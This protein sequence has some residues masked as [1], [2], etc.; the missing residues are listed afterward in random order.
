MIEELQFFLQHKLCH[1]TTDII[2]AVLRA[3]DPA[4]E[5]GMRSSILQNKSRVSSYADSRTSDVDYDNFNDRTGPCITGFFC[6][7]G[8]T[9]VNNDAV[10]C[11]GGVA[12]NNGVSVVA[13]Y[14]PT[15]QELHD[16]HVRPRALVPAG[17]AN[18]GSTCYYNA[19]VQALFVTDA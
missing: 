8:P 4:E 9:V 15:Q 1:P 17:I 18:I 2:M 3:H 5:K 16:Q 7:D 11:G 6:P 13:T 14:V 19:I 10:S 12:L